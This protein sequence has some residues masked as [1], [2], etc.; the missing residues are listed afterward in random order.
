MTQYLKVRTRRARARM[1]RLPPALSGGSLARREQSIDSH[2]IDEGRRG[3]Q[4]LALAIPGALLAPGR[5]F[6]RFN[7][8]VLR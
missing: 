2:N 8:C 7:H 1:P 3:S 6:E 4:K 5:P